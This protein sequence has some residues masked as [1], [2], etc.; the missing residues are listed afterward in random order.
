MVGKLRKSIVV[1]AI[2]CV[3]DDLPGTHLYRIL[4]CLDRSAM[5]S[6]QRTI[7]FFDAFVSAALVNVVVQ[8]FIKK[9]ISKMATNS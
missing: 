9:L 6:E 8:R 5:V 1:A 4:K 2:A 3:V 7:A